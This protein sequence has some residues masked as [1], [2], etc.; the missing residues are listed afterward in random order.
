MYAQSRI[1]SFSAVPKRRSCCSGWYVMLNLVVVLKSHNQLECIETV[2]G[3]TVGAW[4]L[5]CGSSAASAAAPQ[6]EQ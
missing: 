4:A 5:V 6:A 1:I 2:R 3:I